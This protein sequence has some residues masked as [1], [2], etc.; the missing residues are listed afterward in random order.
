MSRCVNAGLLKMI[1]V[2]NRRLPR[3][4]CEV[5]IKTELLKQDCLPLSW[6]DFRTS[7]NMMVFYSWHPLCCYSEVP[8]SKGSNQAWYVGNVAEG[9]CQPQDDP[10]QWIQPPPTQ[11]PHTAFHSPLTASPRPLDPGTQSST[12]GLPGVLLPPICEVALKRSYSIVLF[13]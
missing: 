5:P 1:L 4:D 7:V 10:T 13:K 8:Y 3:G 6:H 2:P 9:E 12:C 11:P